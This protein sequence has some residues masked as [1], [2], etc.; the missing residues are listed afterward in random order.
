MAV[1]I[2]NWMAVLIINWIWLSWSLIDQL[3]WSLIEWLSWSLIEWLSWS[4]ID[5]TL[6][7]SICVRDVKCIHTNTSIYCLSINTLTFINSVNSTIKGITEKTN[8]KDHWMYIYFF[9]VGLLSVLRGHSLFSSPSQWRMTSDFEGISIPDFI[10]LHLFSCL[11]SWER[12]STGSYVTKN[13]NSNQNKSVDIAKFW[14]ICNM[15]TQSS[16]V[17]FNIASPSI[18]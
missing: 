8:M 10:P 3:P 18:P 11:N 9:S 6:G 14:P 7:R 12:A 16:G 2:F 1:L 17:A 5:S 15:R 13:R 4:Y